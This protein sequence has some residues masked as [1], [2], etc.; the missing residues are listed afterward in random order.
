MPM[1]R[2][3]WLNKLG[4]PTKARVESNYEFCLIFIEFVNN[5]GLVI[6]CLADVAWFEIFLFLN[7]ENKET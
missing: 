2:Y 1:E 4:G 7:G 5:H 3:S 6:D